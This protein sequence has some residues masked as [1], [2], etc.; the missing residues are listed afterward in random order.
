MFDVETKSLES[1]CIIG[2]PHN[3]AYM[4]ISRTYT[5]LWQLLVT[6]QMFRP[7][8]VGAAVYY[9]DPDVPPEE[10][11]R[12]FAAVSAPGDVMAKVPRTE[13]IL[14]GGDHAVLTF[15][16]SYAAYEWLFRTWLP[17]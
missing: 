7:G 4:E 14:G 12:S 3:G 5:Q 6:R 15:K 2:L 17:G 8:M 13:Q 9:D 11:L 1:M 16:G 10:E